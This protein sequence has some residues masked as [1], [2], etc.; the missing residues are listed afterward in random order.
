VERRA[1]STPADA[2]ESAPGHVRL[3]AA[4]RRTVR[5][6]YTLC[7]AVHQGV[8][9]GLLDAGG[10]QDITD[11]HYAATNHRVAGDVN[12]FS[13][14]YNLRGFFAWEEAAYDA[15]F[16]ACASVLVGSAG[17]GREALAVARRGMKVDAFDC[18]P[19]LVEVCRALLASQAV[20]ARVMQ[21]PPSR[22]PETLPMY[23]GAI[24]GWTA[25]NHV[26][27]RRRRVA[28]LEAYRR[29]IKPGGP[30]LISFFVWRPSKARTVAYTLGRAIRAVRFAEPLERGAACSTT[31][32][33]HFTEQEIREDLAEAGF[34][35]PYY[36]EERVGHAVGIARRSP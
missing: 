23:D 7:D 30:L 28:L 4:S 3:F 1:V 18:N 10:W 8:W 27:G 34:D 6:I 33:H 25:Y 22:V 19:R 14:V 15:H 9:L 31:F 21:A 32:D 26:I 5:Q 17:G 16:A 24:L 20:D 36:R 11:E 2:A 12:Y 29:H 35:V 13:D